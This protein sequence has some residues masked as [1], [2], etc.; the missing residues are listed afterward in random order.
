MRAESVSVLEMV[1]ESARSVGVTK[2]APH[3]LRRPVLGSATHREAS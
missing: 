2:L 1:K 3:D